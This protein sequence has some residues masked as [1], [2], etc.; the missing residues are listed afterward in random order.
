MTDPIREMFRYHTWA[1]L[2]LIDHCA[3]LPPGRL[4]ETI[5]GTMG[6]IHDTLVHLIVS[7]AGY[8]ARMH[9]DAAVRITDADDL[10]LA[11]LRA[12]FV[13]RSNRW[14]AVLDDLDAFDPMIP[15]RED[16]PDL[17]HVRDLLLVQAIHHGNDHR[18]HICS[19]LGAKGLDVPETDA[20]MYW[21][22]TR[23]IAL[24]DHPDQR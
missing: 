3:A 22:E 17:P 2:K 23:R 20:W 7:D 13:D 19:I 16:H 15:A 12:H 8:L 14:E 18:T 6:T 10:P 9:A 4:D 24:L 21:F 11:D 5:P 1:T